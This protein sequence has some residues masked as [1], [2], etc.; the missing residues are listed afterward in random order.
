MAAARNT[1]LD[2]WRAFAVLGVMWLHWA[3]REWRGA[4]PFEMGLYFFLVLT[5]FFVTRLCLHDRDAGRPRAYRTFL[6][7]RGLRIL[8][9]CTAAMAIGWIAG[10][11]DL[12]AH[13]LWYLSQLSNFHIARLPE[14]PS[15]TSHYWTLAIQ[16]QFYLLWPLLVL[17]C[18]RRALAPLILA[19]ILAAPLSRFLLATF[20]PDLPH[21]GAVTGCALDY[22]GT[23]ALLALSIHRGLDPADLRLKRAALAAGVIYLVLYVLDESGRPL[24]VLRYFQQSFLSLA[25]AGVIAASIT[26]LPKWLAASLEHSAT[27]HVARLSY[28]LY[29]LH[30]IIPIAL[31]HLAPFLWKLPDHGPGLAVRLLAFALASWGAAWLSW[32]YIEVPT[33]GLRR[34]ITA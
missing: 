29:L 4:I 32:R 10:A 26:G 14:W 28:S 3:P 22:L 5:G 6:T 21:P 25:L 33:E 27:Q 2:G 1:Q 15:G 34:R 9:P 19:I 20:L 17:F 8:V 12:R 7:R 30:T 16:S 23:G 24:P 18:P 31:G 11:P 13:P